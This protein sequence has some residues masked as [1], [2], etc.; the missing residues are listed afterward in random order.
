MVVLVLKLTNYHISFHLVV[1]LLPWSLFFL[2]SGALRL[3]RLT[4]RN[5]MCH[6]LMIIVNSLGSI[7]CVIN[8]M[9]SIVERRF[10]KKIISVQSD[11]GGEYEHLKY[12]FHKLG[13]THQVSYP[14]PPPYSPTKRCC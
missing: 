7:C 3:T 10:D 8:L 6:S 14:P 12:Y 2:M 1:L 13:I 11:C 4:V 9:S 5:I